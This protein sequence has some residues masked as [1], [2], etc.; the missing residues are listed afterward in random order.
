MSK[1]ANWRALTLAILLIRGALP[2]HADPSLADTL[3]QRAQGE[4]ARTRA[5]VE[6][7]T[8]APN[9][10]KQAEE[11]LADAQDQ[12]TLAKTLYGAV[13][14]QDMT[15]AE[16]K[17]MVEAASQR[18]DRQRRL[19]DERRD[20]VDK[21][22]IARS[23]VADLE[24]ELQSR[25]NVLDLARNRVSLLQ[26]LRAMAAEEERFERAARPKE[27]E[28]RYEGN[29]QFG[30]SDLPPHCGAVRKAF[31]PCPSGERVRIDPGSSV[32]GVGS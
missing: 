18:V 15:D 19:V 21:G 5:L 9:Q 12:L 7:G 2:S 32:D 8:L 27:M 13:R 26:D 28:I 16:A 1:S 11:R 4:L 20:L 6:N 30:L 17:T 23:E 25:H 24:Q 22:I 14:V 3:V 10:L 31:Q 29:G